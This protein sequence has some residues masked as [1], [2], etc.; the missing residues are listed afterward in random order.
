MKMFAN[1][2]ENEFGVWAGEE[3]FF[4]SF[5]EGGWLR[6]FRSKLKKFHKLLDNVWMVEVLLF[7]EPGTGEFHLV[8]VDE[9]LVNWFDVFPSTHSLDKGLGWVHDLCVAFSDAEWVPSLS[10]LWINRS[11]NIKISINLGHNIKCHLTHLSDK[12]LM[13]DHMKAAIPSS[14]IGVVSW[15]G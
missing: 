2:S 5:D 4:H 14:I 12:L 9:G 8:A 7:I 13:E 15:A 11:S 1:I 6:L 10:N 3:L